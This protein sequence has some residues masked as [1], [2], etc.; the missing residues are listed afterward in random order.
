MA[1]YEIDGQKYEIPDEIQGDKLMETLTFLSEQGNGEAAGLEDKSI[2]PSVKE[3]SGNIVSG[4]EESEITFDDIDR[5]LLDIPGVPALAEF[6]AGANRSIAGFLDFLGPDNINAVLEI[7]GSEKRIPTL[8]D[9]MTSKGGFLEPGLLQKSIS[10]AGELAP[11]AL[12]IG[13]TL[14]K[15]AG[16]LPSLTQA[17]ESA[18]AGVLRQTAATTAKQ[19]LVLGAASGVGQEVG[20]EVNGETGA[21]IGGIAG[22]VA[23]IAA[24][25]SSWR[26]WPAAPE[27]GFS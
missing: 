5:A 4:S 23:A 24:A 10:A 1:V 7:S 12:A 18:G 20:R 27:L 13:A 22:P 15:L 2:A 8:T 9:T 14:R 26:A 19:D 11:S 17:T 3:G 16:Q 25:G 21:L 6:A